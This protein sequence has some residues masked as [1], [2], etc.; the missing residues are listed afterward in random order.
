MKI[1][2]ISE[3]K[4]NKNF[5]TYKDGTYDEMYCIHEKVNQC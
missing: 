3:L 2:I 4:V 1:L 5:Y